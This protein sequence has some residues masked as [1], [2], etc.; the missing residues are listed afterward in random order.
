MKGELFLWKTIHKLDSHDNEDRKLSRRSVQ[1]S[2][3][4]ERV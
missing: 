1:G 2:S 3:I 4:L